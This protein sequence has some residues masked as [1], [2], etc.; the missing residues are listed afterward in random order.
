MFIQEGLR[1]NWNLNF[2]LALQVGVIFF[3]WDLKTHYKKIVNTNLEPKNN[4]DCFS[5]LVPYSNNFLVICICIL[6]FH[7]IYSPHP[8]IFFFVGTRT[9]FRILQLGSGKISN[10]L[11]TVC[12]EG[13][14]FNF[15]E[16]VGL[17]DRSF[18]SIKPSM[19]NH[20]NSRI[21]DGKIMFHV[22]T[23]T[24]LTFT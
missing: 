2:E 1:S 13:P 9:F 8:Q 4:F 21:V 5:L 19:T 15:W 22:C 11:G 3:R 12:I 6:I 23:L 20:V 14:N 17:G 10:S 18:S 16:I 24:F 7:G